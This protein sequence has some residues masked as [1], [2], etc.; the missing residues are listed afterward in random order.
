[1]IY[2]KSICLFHYLNF[3]FW[4]NIFEL[5]EC[6]VPEAVD[7]S[8]LLETNED[9]TELVKVSHGNIKTEVNEKKKDKGWYK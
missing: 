3:F 9:K 8:G 1:M 4:I 7:T 2:V 6:L 5:I